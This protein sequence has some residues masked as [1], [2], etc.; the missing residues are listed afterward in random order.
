MDNQEYYRTWRFIFFTLAFAQF[1]ASLLVQS[2][3][4]L[5]LT[6]VWLAV[7]FN[8]NYELEQTIKGE[9]HVKGS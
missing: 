1:G 7:G 2:L 5:A 8:A 9:R 3:V 4:F 6:L